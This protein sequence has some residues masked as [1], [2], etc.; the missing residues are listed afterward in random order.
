MSEEKNKKEESKVE[1]G[2]KE[3]VEENEVDDSKVVDAEVEDEDSKM[4]FEVVEPEEDL[5][6]KIKSNKKTVFGILILL[7]LV[8]GGYKIYD[9]Y[10]TPDSVSFESFGTCL[11]EADAVLY[12]SSTCP[13]CTKQLE[14]LKGASE[15]IE[16]HLCQEE[17][18]LCTEKQIQG[19][20]AWY[21]NNVSVMGYKTLDQLTEITGCENPGVTE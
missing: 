4:D 3:E 8:F 2:R 6:V 11:K 21:I 7:L 19:V 13:W 20:P 9:S 1:E 12:Y 5:E 14:E 15:I 16:K 17:P 18:E 10:S